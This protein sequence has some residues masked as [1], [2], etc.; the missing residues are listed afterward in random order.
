LGKKEVY[1]TKEERENVKRYTSPQNRYKLISYM[2]RRIVL[3][4]VLECDP[5]DIKYSYNEFGKPYE[6][7][8]RIYFNVS[9]TKNWF[10]I[11]L[12][13]TKE[14]GID[15]EVV[16]YIPKMNSFINSFSTKEEKNYLL[17]NK[18]LE[19]DIA[20][21]LNWC[22]K[23]SCV[24]AQGNGF[25]EDLK[26]LNMKIDLNN[27]VKIDD[28]D[29]QTIMWYKDNKKIEGLFSYYELYKQEVNMTIAISIKLTD[30]CDSKDAV[31]EFYYLLNPDFNTSQFILTSYGDE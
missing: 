31:H 20:T 17:S 12:S 23:E 26:Q 7:K 22:L 14:I 25:E 27:K 19:R 8:N 2:I 21:H 16:Q 13:L 24:K 29:M 4:K 5:L 15:A 28:Y 11:G 10:I 3:A 30:K 6:E 9:H 18:G 1:S